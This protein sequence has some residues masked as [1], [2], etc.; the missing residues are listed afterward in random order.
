M[1][2]K[3][4]IFALLSLLPTNSARPDDLLEIM[5]SNWSDNSYIPN[6]QNN[7]SCYC[8]SNDEENYFSEQ[9]PDE[10]IGYGEE[11]SEANGEAYSWD[12]LYLEP[13]Y[14]EIIY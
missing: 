11:N 3:T 14:P 6:R 2:T 13:A 1:K 5:K 8:P 12:N 4:I 7:A 10:K 9:S